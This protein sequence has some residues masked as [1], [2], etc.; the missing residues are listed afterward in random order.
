MKLACWIDEFDHYKLFSNLC[1]DQLVNLVQIE[2]AV[3][4]N[5][6]G[7][8]YKLNAQANFVILNL[9]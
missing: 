8:C 2:R 6:G 9:N 7:F 4:Q 3:F 5:F 1:D